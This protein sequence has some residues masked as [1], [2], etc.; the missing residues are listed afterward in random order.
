[1]ISTVAGGAPPA[2]PVVGLGLSLGTVWGIAVDGAG[3][4]YF[5]SSTLNSVFRLD[6][7]GLLMLVAGNSR[8]G[9][10]GDGGPATSAQ[11][12]DPRGVAVD[13]AGNLFI[14][15]YSNARIRKV[16]CGG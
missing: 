15:D 12:N 14:A 9:Y 4:A 11:L 8:P 16:N 5:A 13:K 10:S 3:N 7:S 6:P 2:T 1:V